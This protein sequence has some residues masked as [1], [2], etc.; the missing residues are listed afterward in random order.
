[1]RIL[2]I[3]GSLQAESG[4]LV[5][6]RAAATTAPPG[7]EVRLSDG[8]RGLPHFNPDIELQ[9]ATPDA[10]R[11][12]R[13]EIAASDALLIATPEY[14]HSLPGALKNAIDW[15]IGTGELHRKVVG[16]TA[17]TAAAGRGILGIQALQS[18]LRAVDAA[19]VGGAPTV[20]GPDFEHD[21][22]ALV[23]AV[24]EAVETARL[25]AAGA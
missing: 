15:V 13:A 12:W 14:G 20:R 19:I 23:H 11:A 1:M 2:A 24:V 7:I 6:L 22:A 16:V 18:T 5:L 21:V 10:V 17:A 9:G 8:L 3:C 25:A 4:N